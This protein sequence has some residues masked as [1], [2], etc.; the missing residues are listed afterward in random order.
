MF[1]S[2]KKQICPTC[3]HAG[4]AKT[5]PKGSFV[6]ELFLWILGLGAAFTVVF[7]WLIIVP[8]FY[9]MWRIFS[10]T[11]VCATCK[12]PGLIPLDSPRG[13]ELAGQ[14]GVR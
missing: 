8:F 6:V 10:R 2:Y 14:Y 7:G 9:S 12:Q 13:K 3:G 5:V 4:R 1:D 11:P